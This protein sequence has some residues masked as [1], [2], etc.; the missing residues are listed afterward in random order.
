MLSEDLDEVALDITHCA[1]ERRAEFADGNDDSYVYV[2][3]LFFGGGGHGPSTSK[4]WTSI[5]PHVCQ[6]LG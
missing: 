3:I 5:V 1:M 2:F 4:V 6:G